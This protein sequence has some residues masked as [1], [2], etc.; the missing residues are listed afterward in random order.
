[1]IERVGAVSEEHAAA[2]GVLMSSL[3]C[4]GTQQRHS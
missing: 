1:M 2:T 4:F 3:A